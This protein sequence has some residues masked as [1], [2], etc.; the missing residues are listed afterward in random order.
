VEGLFDIIVA[1]VGILVGVVLVLLCRIRRPLTGWRILGLFLGF[2]LAILEF[3][4][5]CRNCCSTPDK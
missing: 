4:G 1:V 5:I 3:F 2:F